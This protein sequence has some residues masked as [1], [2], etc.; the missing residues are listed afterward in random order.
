[1]AKKIGII[2]AVVIVLAAVFCLYQF[3]DIFGVK[4]EKP[5]ATEAAVAPAETPAPTEAPA[6]E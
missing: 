3:T 2:C 4:Q 6:E 1:M 5:A